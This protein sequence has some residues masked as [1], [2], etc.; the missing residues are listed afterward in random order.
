MEILN[1]KSPLKDIPNA[2]TKTNFETAIE[3]KNI[4]FKYEDDLVLKNFQPVKEFK[5]IHDPFYIEGFDLLPI[6]SNHSS[7]KLK[8]LQI[9]KVSIP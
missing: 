7:R 8:S 2:L 6:L 4:S 9:K 1:S 5:K 3:I